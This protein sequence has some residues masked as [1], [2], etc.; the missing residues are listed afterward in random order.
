MLKSHAVLWSEQSLARR[1]GTALLVGSLTLGLAACGGG[2]SL[3]INIGDDFDFSPPSISIAASP[4]AVRAGDSV[5]I[6]AAAADE[7]GI[8]AVSFY[9]LDGNSAVLLG[10]VGSEPYQWLVVA[11]GDGRAT[12]RV[13]AT[14]LDRAGNRADSGTVSVDIVP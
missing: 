4:S 13:F 14:A 12:L 2:F 3:G 1:L 10:S 11:P 7:S 6:V 5:R 9:R 8:E